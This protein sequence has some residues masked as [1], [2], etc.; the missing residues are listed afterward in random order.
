MQANFDLAGVIDFNL[1]VMTFNQ[2]LSGVST[3]VLEQTSKIIKTL[4]PDAVVVQGDTTTA[5]F[6]A[7][8]AFYLK[9]PVV[10]VEAGLRTRNI[11]S[12][13]PEEANR[14]GIGSLASLHFPATPWARQ[15]LLGESKHAYQIVMTGNPVVDAL[16]QTLKKPIS[17]VVKSVRGWLKEATCN[18]MVLL[19]AHRRENQGARLKAIVSASGRL[20]KKH[21][22]VCIVYPVHPNPNIRQSVEEAVP[23]ASFAQ[24][25]ARATA[26]ALE[27]GTPLP[28]LKGEFLD[29][30][31]HFEVGLKQF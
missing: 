10:H 23:S 8:A 14:N 26:G 17:P 28:P 13:F 1:D 27:S 11:N 24:L 4:S 12:P 30:Q 7:W 9:V 18:R 29:D 31:A 6:V 2:T 5:A 20:L 3:K 21:G 25:S 22:D 16:Y 19:T 15:N